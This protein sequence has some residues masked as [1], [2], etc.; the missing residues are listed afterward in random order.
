MGKAATGCQ[1]VATIRHNGAMAA[2]HAAALRFP[3]LSRFAAVAG[4]ALALLVPLA[5]IKDKV[6]E[7]R[8]R[9]AAVQKSFAEETSAAQAIAGPVLMVTCEESYIDERTVHREDGKS[10]T[11]RERK[12]RA[13]APGMFLPARLSIEGEVPIETRHRGI[14]PIQ[15]YAAALDLSGAFEL[16]PPPAPEPEITRVWKDAY[17]VLAIGDVRGIKNAPRVLIAAGSHEFAPGTLDSRSRSGLHAHIGSYADLTSHPQLGFRILLSLAGTGALHIAPLGREN[18]IRVASGWPHPSFVGAYSPDRRQVDAQ[19]FRAEW[20]VTHFATGGQAYWLDTLVGDK[21]LSSPRLLGFALAEPVNPYSMSYRAIEY[22]F[23]FILLTFVAFAL[24]ELV[25]RVRL[26]P[27]QYALTG[28]ALAV[29]FLLLIAL[30]EHIGFGWAYLAA[31]A[32]C[33]MLLTFYL[34]Y[35]LG[36]R[37]RAALFTA[38]FAAHY[39][40]L[41]VLLRSEDHSLLL[42]SVLVFGMLASAMALTRKLD[43]ASLRQQSDPL[44]APL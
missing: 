29:F 19:G 3:I 9:A 4:V 16:P 20:Q 39:G 23:L 14:Y 2:R 41:Y 26:H 17:V 32:S 33:V 27:M 25:W 6:A 37:I 30:S 7:R 40:A 44:P 15:L 11:V 1:R 24:V 34:R 5:T 28:S 18:F 42:G 43:W 12:R 21:L 10:L 36:G 38:L 35:A 13:C 31:S 8:E 22:G